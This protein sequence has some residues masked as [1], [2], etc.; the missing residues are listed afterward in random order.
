M[1]VF[2][3]AEQVYHYVYEQFDEAAFEHLRIH[4][5]DGRNEDFTRDGTQSH[6]ENVTR[7]QEMMFG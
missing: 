2:E 6:Q 1:R 5:A 7:L 3:T 4:R